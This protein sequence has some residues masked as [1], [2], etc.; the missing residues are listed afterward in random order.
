MLNHRVNIGQ[1]ERLVKRKDMTTRE[2]H[3]GPT[4][5]HHVACREG[6]HDVR[7]IPL[8]VSLFVLT[9]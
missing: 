7:F 4:F 6:E 3:V 8:P 5:V 1:V 2:V 9:L